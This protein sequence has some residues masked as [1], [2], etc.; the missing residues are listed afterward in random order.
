MHTKRTAELASALVEHAEAASILADETRERF[1]DIELRVHDI[2]TF[3]D[4]SKTELLGLI[5]AKERSTWE[6]DR[7]LWNALDGL[8]YRTF[9]QRLRWLLMGY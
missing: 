6:A 5:A 7:V 9:W 1:S 2:E 3:M 4:V 8:R